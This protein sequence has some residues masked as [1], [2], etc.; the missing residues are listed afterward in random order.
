MTA[1]GETSP[2]LKNAVGYSPDAVFHK[3]LDFASL[4][5]WVNAA[6]EGGDSGRAN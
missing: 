3:P 5:N 6:N 1:A 2:I 4:R